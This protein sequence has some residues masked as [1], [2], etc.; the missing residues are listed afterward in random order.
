MF[1]AY[2]GSPSDR[3]A[4]IW[5]LLLQTLQNDIF[6]PRELGATFTEPF[7]DQTIQLRHLWQA[8]Y[9]QVE[10]RSSCA[11]RSPEIKAIPV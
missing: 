3:R 9:N 10:F 6:D 2:Q 1:C 11:S 5:T 4:Q 8:F 7:K